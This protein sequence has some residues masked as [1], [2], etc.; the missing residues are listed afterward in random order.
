VVLER[1]GSARPRS[2]TADRARA[3]SRAI[4]CPAVAGGGGAAR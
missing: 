4:G 3:L 2:V 1:W